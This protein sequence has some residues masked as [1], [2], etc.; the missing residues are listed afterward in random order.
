[1]PTCPDCQRT[2]KQTHRICR[3]GICS[4]C[5]MRVRDLGTHC[6][7]VQKVSSLNLIETWTRLQTITNQHVSC[8]GCGTQHFLNKNIHGFRKF[9]NIDLC[10]D[11]YN[12]PQITQHV[13][14]MRRQLLEMDVRNGKW[15]CALC[16]VHLFDPVTLLPLRAFERDHI[17]VFT[18]TST[19][20]ELLV[21]GA[22]LTQIRAE[23]NKCRNL[24]VRCHSAVTCA[25]RAV[26]ILRLKA[27]SRPPHRPITL[28]IQKRAKYQVDTLTKMLLGGHTGSR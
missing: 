26:G 1:M 3:A 12:I 22:P 5:T 2:Y 9:W 14:S 6:C 4:V 13:Q 21:T 27:I 23:N 25:E 7:P 20:W 17:D 24:C 10:W 16:S 15:Q 19:V 28:Y 11:C 8:L 18:K